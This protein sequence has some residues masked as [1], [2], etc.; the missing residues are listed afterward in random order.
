M[1]AYAIDSAACDRMTD[2]SASLKVL[3]QYIYIALVNEEEEEE[4]EEHTL[5]GATR[6]SDSKE[7]LDLAEIN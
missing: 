3:P 2:K 1:C 7:R 4:E 6:R 5:E